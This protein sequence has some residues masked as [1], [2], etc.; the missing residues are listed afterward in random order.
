M[1]NRSIMK[2]LLTYLNTA[3]MN[4][5][6]YRAAVHIAPPSVNPDSNIVS[7]IQ[8]R[9][10]QAPLFQDAQRVLGSVWRYGSEDRVVAATATAAAATAYIVTQNPIYLPLI[11]LSGLSMGGVQSM[12]I[13]IGHPRAMDL[14]TPYGLMSKLADLRKLVQ[15]QDRMRIENA[16]RAA[17]SYFESKRASETDAKKAQ[18][19]IVNLLNQGYSYSQITEMTGVGSATLV[20]IRKG[21]IPYQDTIR[22]FFEG[23]SSLAADENK[24]SP[25]K[26]AIKSVNDS[27]VLGP[28]R[29]TEAQVEKVFN[30]IRQFEELGYSRAKICRVAG[31]SEYTMATWFKGYRDISNKATQRFIKNAERVLEK[32]ALVDKNVEDENLITEAEKIAVDD[33]FGKAVQQLREAIPLTLAQLAEIAAID[34]IQLRKIEKGLVPTSLEEK[35]LRDIF[36]MADVEVTEWQRRFDQ[37]CKDADFMAA[38]R[39]KIILQ[40]MTM[41]QLAESIGCSHQYL[42]LVEDGTAPLSEKYEAKI[43][44]VLGDDLPT[45]DRMKRKFRLHGNRG[46]FLSGKEMQRERL[47]QHLSV[48]RLA[49]MAGVEPSVI[50]LYEK[51]RVPHQKSVPRLEAVLFVLLREWAIAHPLPNE[52]YAWSI[53][54]ARLEMGMNRSQL[55]KEIG[56]SNASISNAE[57]GKLGSGSKV[58]KII[59]KFLDIEGPYSN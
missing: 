33:G 31:I 58:I 53:R 19:S 21:Y 7:V 3:K 12:P 35:T 8:Q 22:C 38:V 25:V 51:G 55:A 11:I 23:V 9:A 26:T 49:D 32:I 24:Y 39:L 54:N 20:K 6:A 30:L 48:T 18:T 41:V 13:P 34:V 59:L 5:N 40:K 16:L 10:L 14:N 4:L 42:S 52:Y 17:T 28:K 50:R 15:T 1:L 2:T 43:R 45:I 46:L 36:G 29:A 27:P 57:K 47:A 56:I 37:A 44:G